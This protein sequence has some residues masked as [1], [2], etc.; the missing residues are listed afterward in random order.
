MHG[1]TGAE[2]LVRKIVESSII[3]VKPSTLFG[4][5]FRFQDGELDA[6]GLRAHLMANGDVKCVAIGKAAEAMALEVRKRLGDRV[7]GIVATP[8]VR[9]L[10]VRGFDFYKTGHPLPDEESMRAADAVRE[11]VEG[12][13]KSD[14]LLFLISGGGSAAIFSPV[15]GVTLGESNRL[16]EMMLN[17]GVP[18]AR[19]NLV[20][21]HLSSLGGGKLAAL[22][23][24][25]RKFSLLISDVVGDDSSTIA[26]GPTV[27]DETSPAD[28]LRFLETSGIALNIPKSIPAELMRQIGRRKFDVENVGVRII[29]SNLDALEAAEK[30]GIENGYSS[31]V[32]T[33]FWESAAE[34]AAGALLSIA[35]STELD[36]MPLSQPA[37]VLVAGETTVKV[38]GGGTGGRNQHLV[39]C[40]LREFGNLAEKGTPLKKTVAFS[41]GTD[42]KD[43]NSDAA[44]AFASTETFRKVPG[45]IS[46]IQ[47]YIYRNDSNNFFRKYG[48]LIKTGPT[49]TNVMD[50]FGIVVG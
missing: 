23:P 16:I 35:R 42:G 27:A 18:I 49:D 13:S 45:G 30:V 39:L 46:E 5:S 24:R 47:D 41:F 10:D 38:S 20:R 43:G 19:V 37:L 50:I 15:E 3:A 31:A 33:R 17:N 12:S 9:H 8:V 40:A 14:L 44:G 6:F 4:R 1:G 29:G 26:G 48:G 2:Q 34:G 25:Q 7:T 36:S 22:A 32:L 21:R 28:A 11:L